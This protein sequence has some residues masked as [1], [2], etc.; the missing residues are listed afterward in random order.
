M[1]CSSR[2]G[3]PRARV[4]ARSCLRNDPCPRKR[5]GRPEVTNSRDNEAAK[6][7]RPSTQHWLAD[8]RLAPAAPGQIQGPRRHP[9]HRSA[10]EAAQTSHEVVAAAWWGRA[11][12]ESTR[13]ERALVC[14]IRA[15]MEQT[16]REAS[17]GSTRCARVLALARR[18]QRGGAARQR[19]PPRLT[20]P[21]RPSKRSRPAAVQAAPSLGR[22]RRLPLRGAGQ[23]G[24]T[25]QLS[26]ARARARPC[27]T[28]S[29]RWRSVS[30]SRSAAEVWY[31]PWALRSTLAPSGSLCDPP[32]PGGP[33]LP[34]RVP[35]AQRSLRARAAKKHCSGT[36]FAGFSQNSRAARKAPELRR[37]GRLVA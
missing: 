4:A 13:L 16:G 32:W 3:A 19:G 20:G 26:A 14:G 25:G 8:H 11:R 33:Q 18:K 7:L 30:R 27:R 12:R 21:G 34:P 2:A 29:A 36:T 37:M 22:V 9:A 17:W 10:T 24:A 31:W 15:P 1:N 35:T 6:C 28:C 23:T 5:G